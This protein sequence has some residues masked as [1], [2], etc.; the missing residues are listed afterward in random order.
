MKMLLR[1]LLFLVFASLVSCRTPPTEIVL[2]VQT[3]IDQGPGHTLT[4]VRVR[5]APASTP[6]DAVLDMTYPLGTRGMPLL[7]A[8][9][10]ITPRDN[11]ARRSVLVEVTAISNGTDLFTYRAIAPFEAQHTN[12]LDVFLANRCTIQANRDMCTPSQTC[13]REG[14]ENVEHTSLPPFMRDA[15][16]DVA[17][18]ETGTDA[19]SID[20]MDALDSSADSGMD[21]PADLGI[22]VP[23][24]TV[25]CGVG[26]RNCGGACVPVDDVHNCGACGHDCGGLANIVPS[27]AT[28]DA[29]TCRFTCASDFGNCDSVP[30]NG[31]EADL[32]ANPNCGLCGT[33]C[34]AGMV[35]GAT[36]AGYGCSVS[37][38]SATPTLCGSTCVDTNSNAANCGACG[39]ACPAP[40]S[41]GSASCVGGSCT[42]VC[43]GGYHA[44]NGQCVSDAAVTSCGSACI[45][46]PIPANSTATCNGISCGF[47]CVP[48]F[49]DCD[50]NAANGCEQALDVSAHCGSCATA[51]ATTTPLCQQTTPGVYACVSSCTAGGACNPA[52]PCQSG[53]ISCSTGAPVCVPTSNYPVGSACRG[54]G[55]VCDSTAT[56]HACVA[57]TAC[58]TGNPCVYGATDCSLGMPQCVAAGN[59]SA[60]TMCPGGVCDGSGTCV[61][62][63]TGPCST[64][65]PCT[66]GTISC[67]TGS[68]ICM[69]TGNAAS[70]TPCGASD[71]GMAG[72][73]DGN[74]TCSLCSDGLPCSTGNECEFGMTSCPGNLCTSSGFQPAGTACSGGVCDGSGGCQACTSGSTCT[75]DECTYGRIDCGM[76]W[77][78]CT[79]SGYAPAGTACSGGSCDGSGNCT[80]T[81]VP[82]EPCGPVQNCSQFVSACTPGF[83]CNEVYD[84]PGSPCRYTSGTCNGAGTCRMTSG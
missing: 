70:G 4:D 9:L 33:T 41:N 37:C 40:S 11:D 2:R 48:G 80:G 55:G 77:P 12:L 27:S 46:C 50:G 19:P 61:A 16:V 66:V 79:T 13:G 39:N 49:G 14:C 71:G 68:P 74:G 65:N 52:N 1:T 24:D 73:C 67:A 29:G 45:A 59:V 23:S 7:P 53:T 51:C 15:S 26:F 56:C 82:D 10:G 22:D 75:I 21:A 36:G 17:A 60:G 6:N 54:G 69:T 72:A 38:A 42:I 84:P 20:A 76:G 18:N 63:M 44:C 81:C 35:C 5:V 47:T 31:C 57:G 83:M 3:D 28:C 58:S 78:M 62:C 25:M 43:A 64:G 30:D 8:D 32:R 34:P